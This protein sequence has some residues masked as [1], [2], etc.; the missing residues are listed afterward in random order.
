MHSVGL[1]SLI[2]ARAPQLR[3]PGNGDSFAN[4]LQS[5]NYVA[6][7]DWAWSNYKNTI[8]SLAQ[9]IQRQKGNGEVRLLEIGGGRYPL[10][11]PSEARELGLDITVNDIDAGEL[12]LAP[13]E[14]GRAHFDISGDLN[15]L[16][17]MR[18]SYDVIFSR[19]VM[20]HVADVPKAWCNCYSLLA[21]GGVALAFFP[22]LWAPPFLINAIIPEKLSA[23]ILRLFF[24]DR[25]NGVEPKFPA[26]YDHCRSSKR[27]L[28]TLFDRIG[29]SDH[30]ILPFWNHGYFRAIPGLRDIDRALQNLARRRDWRLISTYAYALARK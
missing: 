6:H 27:V 15:A 30:I 1:S 5:L 13:A 8:V 17:S 26:L 19:M 9:D 29:F 14:F 18:D 4:A 22:T 10:F 7:E 2:I 21:S 28:G 11:S 16:G 23:R 25:H 24:P 3:R 20:E 12:A